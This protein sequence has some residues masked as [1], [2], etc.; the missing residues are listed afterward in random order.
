M[1]PRDTEKTTAQILAKMA[2]RCTVTLKSPP[3]QGSFLEWEL[4]TLL[5][6]FLE[7]HWEEQSQ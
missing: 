6:A 2:K 4:W 7:R 5:V 1:P 3:C